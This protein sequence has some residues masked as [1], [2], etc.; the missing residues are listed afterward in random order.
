MMVQ[1]VRI[2]YELIDREFNISPSEICSSC[3]S[4][5]VVFARG[6][7]AHLL[8]TNTDMS[9]PE[10]SVTFG[11]RCHSTPFTAANRLQQIIRRRSKAAREKRAIVEALINEHR[12]RCQAWLAQRRRSIDQVARARYARIMA[13]LDL[14]AHSLADL[15]RLSRWEV[16]ARLQEVAA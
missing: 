1:P 14:E 11:R 4:R 12:D 16:E 5:P 15:G 8:R 3:R 7:Y 13:E 9:W 2:A 10:I 6:V